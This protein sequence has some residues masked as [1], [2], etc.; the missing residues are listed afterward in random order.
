RYPLINSMILDSGST[1]YIANYLSRFKR[2]P[3]LA[4]PNDYGITVLTLYNVAYCLTFVYN[5]VSLE[6][7][8]RR[9]IW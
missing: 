5:I 1:I 7:L 8:N 6:Q 4:A 2:P 9:G 3:T